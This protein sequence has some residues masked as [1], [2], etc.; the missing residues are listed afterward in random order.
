MQEYSDYDGLGLAD[1]VR[2]GEVS[3]REL[4]QAAIERVRRVDPKLG[5]VVYEAFDEAPARADAAPKDGPFAGVPFFLKDILGELEGWPT[6][7]GSAFMK[8]TT[9]KYTSVLVQRFLAAGLVPLGKTKAP[10]LGLLPVSEPVAYGP[11]RNPWNT[12]HTTG[13]SSGGS[14]ALTASGAVPLAH[15]NDGGGSIRIPASCCGLVGLKPTRARITLGPALGDVMGGFINE[16]IVSRS[17]RDTAAMLDA[18]AGPAPGDPY[19]APPQAKSY[20]DLST[21]DPRPLKIAIAKVDIATG[22]PLAPECV[23]AV[24]R[25]AKL[26]AEL[27]HEVEEASPQLN[28]GELALAF[29]TVWFAGAAWT[30]DGMAA[31]RG[32]PLEEKSFEPLTWATAEAGRAITAPQYLAAVAGI[33]NASRVIAQFLRRYDLFMTS[34]LMTPPVKV[35]RF[36]TSTSDPLTFFGEIGKFAGPTAVANATGGASISLPLHWTADGLPVG[37]MF[38]GDLGAEDIL[39]GLAGQLERA[40]PWASRRPPVWA[41]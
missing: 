27:G 4:A 1:L 33:Q 37:L 40:Q 12:D 32:V 18:V 23:A 24:E 17:V 19:Y 39:L 35:G 5:A 2:R 13:G 25:T 31:M 34:T 10:E 16:L 41:G 15:A 28:A 6:T 22:E 38:S 36:D 20:L 29:F 14:A 11:A 8:G 26:C 30:L 7:S 21:R 3:P 9:A